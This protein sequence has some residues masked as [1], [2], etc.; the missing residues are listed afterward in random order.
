[1]RLILIAAFMAAYPTF[2][3]S[4]LPPPTCPSWAKP[5]T[6]ATVTGG[7]CQPV[8]F[9]G[10]APGLALNPPPT[11]DASGY[12]HYTCTGTCRTKSFNPPAFQSGVCTGGVG[13][14]PYNLPVDNCGGPLPTGTAPSV[15]LAGV[16]TKTFP[17]QLQQQ[18]EANAGYPAGQAACNAMTTQTLCSANSMTPPPNGLLSP[19]PYQPTCC[20][21]NFLGADQ[22]VNTCINNSNCVQNSAT[23]PQGYQW[24]LYCDGT[25]TTW[26][27]SPT[28]QATC[29]F[30]DSSC[31]DPQAFLVKAP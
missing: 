29:L 11:F 10:I 2:G 24:T 7:L 21:P 18:N 15:Y 28:C 20:A 30:A 23:A 22:D 25:P 9:T 26:S 31:A 4:L 1:M 19:V 3:A 5:V 16:T 27:S 6:A 12:E 14:P 17:T 8:T 13:T